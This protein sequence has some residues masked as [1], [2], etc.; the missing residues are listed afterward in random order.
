M[1]GRRGKKAGR[2]GGKEERRK[3]G[4]KE[5]SKAENNNQKK[6]KT[7]TTLRRFDDNDCGV[8]RGGIV[9]VM[10]SLSRTKKDS[11]IPTMSRRSTSR[12][13]RPGAHRLNQARFGVRLPVSRTKGGNSRLGVS[14][15]K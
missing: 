9:D 4:R 11:R 3:E 5:G 7:S 10:H 6:G 15:R 8:G 2:K 14:R 13:H 12:F 1:E